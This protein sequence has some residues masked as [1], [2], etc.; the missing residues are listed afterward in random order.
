MTADRDVGA[1][2]RRAPGYEAG[3]LGRMH[4]EIADRTAA[5]AMRCAPGARRVLDVGCGTGYLLRG[6]ASR[7]P[8]AESLEGIDPAPAMIEAARAAATDGRLSFAEGVAE[9]LPGDDDSFD[10][11]VITTSFDHWRD[12]RAGLRQCARVLRPGG[13]L[14]LCDLF[15][16]W[17]APTL[18]GRRAGKAR[19]PRRATVLVVD[20]GFTGPRWHP[21]YTTLIRAV[22][23]TR[24]SC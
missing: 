22:T 17:L 7:L 18:V 6:L 11:V 16:P 15:S 10:L 21:V 13:T 2:E 20:A 1:F 5:L 8:G 4:R 19:T 9:R 14:V 12:Q 23:A 24:R 3:P